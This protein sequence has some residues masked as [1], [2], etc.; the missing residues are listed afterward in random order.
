MDVAKK[1]SINMHFFCITLVLL[2]GENFDWD[3]Q[4][5]S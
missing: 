2:Q 5:H 3:Q 4:C 1:R